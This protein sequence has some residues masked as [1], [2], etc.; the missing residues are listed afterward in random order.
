MNVENLL[1][2]YGDRIIAERTIQQRSAK[3]AQFPK[4]MNPIIKMG[5]QD[6]GVEKLYIHQE[7]MFREVV[8][9]HNVIITTGTSSGK[10][11]AFCLPVI[12]RMIEYPTAKAIFI[13]PTKALAQDQKANLQKLLD[14]IISNRKILVGTYDGDTPPEERKYIREHANIILTNPDMLNVSIIPNHNKYG[15]QQLIENLEFIVI[16]ELHVYRGAFGSHVSNLMRRINRICENH[17]SNP[18][19][20]CS[21][22]TIANPIEL[23]QNICDRKFVHIDK[24]GS[25]CSEKKI[26]FW[27]CPESSQYDV[28]SEV[29]SIVT[30][31]VI[32][33]ISSITFCQ[34]RR[35]VE[36]ASKEIRDALCKD[37]YNRKNSDKVSAYRSG[38]T[39][40]ERRK[41]EHNLRS[42]KLKGVISTNALELGIDIGSLDVVIMA[43][44]PG[45]IASFW[46]QAGRAGRRSGHSLVI[47][48]L[49]I[50]PIEHYIS[51]NPDWIIESTVE[52]AIVDRNNLYIQM[53]HVRAASYELP[54]SNKDSVVFPDLGE[55]V[56]LLLEAGELTT[57]GKSYKWVDKDDTNPAM[58]IG[59]RNITNENIEVVDTKRE[60]TITTTDLVTAKHE[61]YPGAIYI[62]DGAQ[63]KV[64]ELNL[65]IKQAYVTSVKSD[66]YTVPFV[67]T[68]VIILGVEASQTIQRYSVFWGDV[69][70]NSI[71]SAYKKIAYYNHQNLGFEEL[72]KH[73]SVELDTEGCWLVFPDNVAQFFSDYGNGSEANTGRPSYYDSDGVVFAIKCA[74]EIRTMATYGD[75]GAT[76]FV[77]NNSSNPAIIIYDKYNGG[78]GFSQK[79]YDLID[80]VI[81]DAIKIVESCPCKDGCPSCV[82]HSEINKS[83]VLWALKNLHEETKIPQ[84]KD[85][86]KRK[87]R[88]KIPHIK[89]VDFTFKDA[90]KQWHKYLNYLKQQYP[91]SYYLFVVANK[92]ELTTAGMDF[93]YYNSSLIRD[94]DE[95]D[96]V[97]KEIVKMIRETIMDYNKIKVR[98][99]VE[100]DPEAPRKQAKLKRYLKTR[101]KNPELEELIKKTD[102]LLGETI[103][104]DI[105]NDD[106][107]EDDYEFLDDDLDGYCDEE[108]LGDNEDNKYYK[109]R[110]RK[111]NTTDRSKLETMLKSNKLATQLKAIESDNGEIIIKYLTTHN[112]ETEQINDICKLPNSHKILIHIISHHESDIIRKMALPYIND[113]HVLKEFILGDAHT[114]LKEYAC[115]LIDD[116]AVLA[117]IIGIS[118]SIDIQIAVIKEIKDQLLLARIA[119]SHKSEFVRAK[120][121][122]MIE[123]QEVLE[124]IVNED[125][126]VWV[127]SN[128]V[129][130]ITENRFLS[131]IISKRISD[132]IKLSALSQLTDQ[133]AISKI[134][135]SKKNI[136]DDLRFAAVQR[137]VDQE[138]L[139]FISINDINVVIREAAIH[140]LTDKNT[141]QRLF[142]HDKDPKIREIALHMLINLTLTSLA[143]TVKD[144]Y[145]DSQIEDVL[146]LLFKI[147]SGSYP[148]SIRKIAYKGIFNQD[149]LK[150]AFTEKNAKDIRLV[151]VNNITDQPLLNH[152]SVNDRCSAVRDNAIQRFLDVK[153][154]AKIGT[155]HIT[156]LKNLLYGKKLVFVDTETTGLGTS[157]RICQLSVIEYDGD[158]RKEFS[159]YCNPHAIINPFAYEVHKISQK[160]VDAA[161]DLKNTDVFKIL[162]RNYAKGNLLVF[163]NASFDLRFLSYEGFVVKKPA[164][165][166]LKLA[167]HF[168]C[169]PNNKLENIVEFLSLVYQDM[170]IVIHDAL[171]D[172]RATMF[173]FNWIFECYPIHIARI[174][175]EGGNYIYIPSNIGHASARAYQPNRTRVEIES[176]LD[177]SE[178]SEYSTDGSD[179]YDF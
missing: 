30:D 104:S 150:K 39:P 7:K 80:D 48:L 62:H 132:S 8:N 10:T 142:N 58:E 105:N 75:V 106:N 141:L 113:K 103:Y 46:Q 40:I 165:D 56:N 162:K 176:E 143:K 147:I 130:K 13:Y 153:W 177:S 95:D 120:A 32:N 76:I 136:G 84:I 90:K 179:L 87:N 24:D 121:A 16:D 138:T 54:L 45:T 174:I 155:E 166:T 89:N 12:Q 144:N 77:P 17:G 31:L 171:G 168:K 119:L 157:D 126:S 167:K 6:S 73:L 160:T 146:D 20:L 43:G 125:K 110:S 2:K 164:I 88:P 27:Q 63:Y 123:D 15:F 96:S 145:H 108:E 100:D 152:I 170:N 139:A 59:L 14:H 23:A 158:K 161:P 44:F 47:L 50:S 148:D 137:S 25:F 51:Q 135:L 4:D 41:I 173:L 79:I 82:G 163:H 57:K 112:D 49:S 124:K 178:S 64:S 60:L 3:L 102:G 29:N 5:L 159:S 92:I 116:Q 83:V 107:D 94:E 26:V 34:S 99:I 35:D 37:R 111:L 175:S 11:L 69:K 65:D 74:A 72:A 67:T 118:K 22:A 18:L 71:I 33:N 97:I 55:I 128:A 149:L 91:D 156:N 109:K 19:F 122:S 117:D 52:N 68:D 9:S 78:L 36:V 131:N 129:K 133:S 134:L 114:S 81:Q 53:A 154:A 98:V 21:S 101:Q 38:L 115:S 93:Y 172:A 127:R 85:K 28:I 66:H 70:V 86:D 61:L 1:Q 169:F 42:G 151:A 140:K